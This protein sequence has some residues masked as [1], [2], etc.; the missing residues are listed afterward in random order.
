MP[1]ALGDFNG[2]AALYL[3]ANVYIDAPL[4][5]RNITSGDIAAGQRITLNNGQIALN[6]NGSIE[7]YSGPESDQYRDLAMLTG[8][9]IGFYR[10]RGGAYQFSRSVHRVEVGSSPSGATVVL[11]GY[12]AKQPN[13][14][15]SPRSLP[16]Y[17]AAFGAQ[18]QSWE[19]R[20]DNLRETAVGSG[21]WKFDVTAELGLSAAG[22]SIHVAAGSGITG[23]PG[24][25]SP[26]Q[27]LPANTTELTVNVAQASQRGTG[28]QTAQWAGRMVSF[29]VW[30]KT[31]GNWGAGGWTNTIF[32]VSNHGA[33][34]NSSATVSIPPG[35]T[36]FY[37]EFWAQDVG[38]TYVTGGEQ[39][40]YAVTSTAP[41]ATTISALSDGAYVSAVAILPDY[42]PPAGWEVYEV[43]Y[44]G[45]LTAFNGSTEAPWG[46]A[47]LR[48]LSYG[49]LA[50][51][52]GYIPFAFTI[53]GGY[54]RNYLLLEADADGPNEEYYSPFSWAEVKSHKADIKIRQHQ[55]NSA[56]AQNSFE[57]LDFRWSTAASTALSTG[58]I[59]WIAIGA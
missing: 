42:T 28:V 6:G 41:I 18:D 20:A 51:T 39:Y 2:Q 19:V 59:N 55:P 12:W 38:P 49:S 17:L 58:T 3:G 40:N 4:S 46:L 50:G 32:D 23:A 30:L 54:D 56:T 14:L 7:V 15:V 13:V 35:T 22:G 52:Y 53:A 26:I 5:A 44:S 8:G 57:F 1:F 47:R 24:W 48:S 37:V 16:S 29:R 36:G 9:D 31:S 45:E 33:L 21:V 27:A 43:T 11:P 34:I 25:S 10:W